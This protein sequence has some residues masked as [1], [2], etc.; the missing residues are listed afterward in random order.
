MVWGKSEGLVVGG[1]AKIRVMVRLEARAGDVLRA[2]PGGGGEPV[3]SRGLV[4][5]LMRERARGN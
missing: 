3:R 1:D 4:R 2:E 5:G